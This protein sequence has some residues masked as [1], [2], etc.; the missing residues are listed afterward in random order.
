M[1][2]PVMYLFH[3]VKL[4][5]VRTGHTQTSGYKFGEKRK[6]KARAGAKEK[7]V[8]IADTQVAC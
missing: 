7:S 1:M 3:A 2:K 4:R 5:S 6:M 8:T